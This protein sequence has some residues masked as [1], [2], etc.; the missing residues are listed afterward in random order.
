MDISP[1]SDPR[2]VAVGSLIYFQNS[3]YVRYLESV[4]CLQVHLCT[5]SDFDK[6]PELV[7]RLDGLLLTGGDDVYA[8]AYG[9]DIIAGTWRIDRQRTFFEL[10][11]IEQ[12]RIQRK[13]ILGICRGCQM[14]N[15]A[16]GGSLIQDIPSQRPSAIE[17]R[18]LQR[19]AYATHPVEVHSHSQLGGILEQTSLQVTTSH[20]Q[21]IDKLGHGLVISASAED[22]IAEAIE[23]INPKERI[24]AVQWHPE[25]MADDESS[26][27]LLHHFISLCSRK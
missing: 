20:H 25:G 14:I 1:A 19:P 23:T 22:G 21:A 4:D 12:A 27:R 17:H 5:L 18:S 11:L 2:P 26:K 24:L 8:P 13:P 3:W 6:V 16:C 10:A 15:I 7:S 9:Q